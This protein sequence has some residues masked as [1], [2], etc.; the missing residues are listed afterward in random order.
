MIPR[1]HGRA[2]RIEPGTP[3]LTTD[4][5]EMLLDLL[6]VLGVPTQYQA[7]ALRGIARRCDQRRND[8]LK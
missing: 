6:E 1:R 2:A 8:R 3:K 7:S 4:E 5:E